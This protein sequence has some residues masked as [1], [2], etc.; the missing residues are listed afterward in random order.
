MNDIFFVLQTLSNMMSGT[1]KGLPIKV[2]T[3]PIKVVTTNGTPVCIIFETFEQSVF[4]LIFMGLSSPVVHI[5]YITLYDT[6][7][8]RKQMLKKPEVAICLDF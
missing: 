1:Q 5:T 4:L 2:P 7:L 8:L 6:I 3:I